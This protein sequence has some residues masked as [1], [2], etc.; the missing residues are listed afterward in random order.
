MLN[1]FSA[2]TKANSGA[3]KGDLI[4]DTDTA[5]FKT[6]VMD[7]SMAVPVL[8]DF[9]APWCGPCR[10]LGPTIEKVVTSLKGKVKLV[11]INVDENQALAGQLGIQSIPAVFAFFQGRP[12]DGFMGALPESQI[13]AF[14]DRILQAGGAGMAAGG[15]ELDVKT[16]MAEAEQQ[17]SA[18]DP[19]DASAL[20]SQVLSVEPENLAAIAGLCKCFIMAG[21]PEKAREI[22][23]QM[24]PEQAKDPAIKAVRVSLDLASEAGSPEQIP[25]LEGKLAKDE[26]DHRARFDLAMALFGAHQQEAAI[27]HLLEIFRRDR[28]WNEEAARQQLLKLFEALGPTHPLTLSGRRRLSAL[29]FS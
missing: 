19:A 4:K 24:D 11:K 25:M 18:G 20:Y 15:E 9:W 3:T 8:V 10:Q 2:A 16:L 26:N 12:V 1:K 29:M 27:H 23:G 17:L 28:S 13:K 7:A 14:I 22:L 5:N 6:D 21:E